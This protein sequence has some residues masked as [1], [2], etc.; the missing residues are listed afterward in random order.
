MKIQVMGPGCPRCDEAEKVVR[1]AVEES[2][3][4]AE[5]EKVTDFQAMAS[6]GVF[7]TPGVAVDGQVKLTGRPPS[8]NEVLKWLGK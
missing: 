7:S 8:K 4:E 1:Q 5:I 3:V 6:M 2:G